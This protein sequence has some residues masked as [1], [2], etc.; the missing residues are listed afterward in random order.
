[1]HR[2]SSG[3]KKACSKHTELTAKNECYIDHW[4][5]L[6]SLLLS[7]CMYPV[8][9]LGHFQLSVFDSNMPQELDV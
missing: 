3:H 8:V 7:C 4:N 2:K 9:V 1:M 5:S 6:C